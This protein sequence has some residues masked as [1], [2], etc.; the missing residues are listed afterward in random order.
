VTFRLKQGL[1]GQAIGQLSDFDT[2]ARHGAK[3]YTPRQGVFQ[4]V[5]LQIG[6]RVFTLV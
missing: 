1:H 5:G 3:G 6:Q 2:N 4:V